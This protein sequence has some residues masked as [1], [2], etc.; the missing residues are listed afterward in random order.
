MGGG[1]PPSESGGH[2]VPNLALEVFCSASSFLIE[3]QS[4]FLTEQHSEPGALES[5]A[6]AAASPSVRSAVLD[7][8][9]AVS[10]SQTDGRWPPPSESGGL[11]IGPTIGAAEGE[12]AF[13]APCC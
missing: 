8:A 12:A 5:C 6:A 3:Q 7:A 10:G 11:G 4:L 9:V 2:H 1:R 13:S